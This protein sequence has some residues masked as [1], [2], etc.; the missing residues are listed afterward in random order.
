MHNF[1][2]DIEMPSDIHSWTSVEPVNK[3]YSAE[4]KYKLHSDTGEV[5]LLR[6]SDA[7]YYEAKRKEYEIVCKY[8]RTGI[9]MSSPKAFGTCNQGQNTYMLL[10][11]VE[12]ADLTEILPSLS[13]QEQYQL[14]RQAGRILRKIHSIPL[15]EADRPVKTKVDHKL[16]QLNRYLNSTVR[17]PNDEAAVSYIR[18]NI[19]KIWNQPPV[20]LHGDYHP[21]NLIYSRK[22]VK[23]IDENTQNSG[24]TGQPTDNSSN[25][26]RPMDNSCNTGQPMDACMTPVTTDCT[27]LGGQ[28]GVIDFNRWE[29]GD[30][31]EEFYKLESF[32]IEVSIPYC[33]GQI[34]AYFDDNVPEIF[35][36][37]QA[38]YVAHASLYSIK[39]AEKFGPEN[40]AGMVKR[41]NV[42]YENYD[43]FTR[44]IPKWYNLSSFSSDHCCKLCP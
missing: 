32:G 18:Q 4:K 40:I 19:H 35:W 41:W 44:I 15:E 34:D 6:I 25:A 10:S 17:V 21:G 42:S 8:A 30:P 37:T 16:M 12:G 29:A 7:A 20:Y 22:T 33:I 24:S 2:N 9:R 43:G 38:V 31:Y 26:G 39:W 13:E 23:R 36:E 3:G 11:W 28:I 1:L 5:F 14:G 27:S